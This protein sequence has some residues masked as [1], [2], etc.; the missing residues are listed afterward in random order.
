VNI[1]RTRYELQ[2]LI[3]GKGGTSYD[4]LIQTVSLEAAKKQIQWLKGTPNTNQKKK[5][6]QGLFLMATPYGLLI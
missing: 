3:S 4:A 1:E 5:R 6:S 2:H